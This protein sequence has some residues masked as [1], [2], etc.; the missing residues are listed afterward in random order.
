MLLN[1]LESMKIVQD[2]TLGYKGEQS[3]VLFDRAQLPSG[4]NT[5]TYSEPLEASDL[6]YHGICDPGMIDAVVRTEISNGPN[7]R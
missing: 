1:R 3:R 6:I 4:G 5:M 2:T 7:N